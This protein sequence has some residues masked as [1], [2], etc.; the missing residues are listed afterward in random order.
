M[1]SGSV[2]STTT[3]GCKPVDVFMS[4]TLRWFWK[5]NLRIFITAKRAGFQVKRQMKDNSFVKVVVVART[6]K[7]II[8]CSRLGAARSSS[9]RIETLKFPVFIIVGHPRKYFQVL[10]LQCVLKVFPYSNWQLFGRS[11]TLFIIK[12]QAANGV[13]KFR[14]LMVRR[15]LYPTSLPKWTFSTTSCIVKTNI[16]LYNKI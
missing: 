3:L 10:M 4:L 2:F 13:S 6:C 16:K 12:L 8:V 1:A 14:K 5:S 11:K 15:C 7:W 9:I